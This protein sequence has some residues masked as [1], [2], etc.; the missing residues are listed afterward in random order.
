M[1]HPAVKSLFKYH[2]LTRPTPSGGIEYNC[3]AVD[4]IN[5]TRG[6]FSD[7]VTFND[8]FDCSLDSVVPDH[9]DHPDNAAL[10]KVLTD[11]VTHWIELNVRR[12]GVFSLT[13]NSN[14]MLMWSHYAG[15][16]T[17]IC[18][19][20]ERHS[21]NVLGDLSVTRPVRYTDA[22]P[23]ISYKEAAHLQ[24]QSASLDD[25]ALSSYIY[26]KSSCWSYEREWRAISVTDPSER[27]LELDH[28]RVRSIIFG[29]R[30]R[31]EHKQW[32]RETLQDKTIPFK[33]T[34]KGRQN[35]GL[36]IQN[37]A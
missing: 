4:A 2:W 21:N 29:V 5:Q 27:M 18:I 24:Y 7:P 22:Y 13:E 8:P 32:L 12:Y 14:D 17:G 23:L 9:Y 6:Y 33:K 35:F 26:T 31:D 15:Q 36:V 3:Y 16:H 25:S 10:A 20:Y 34:V 11:D 28:V 30:T 37:D 1:I 19:E